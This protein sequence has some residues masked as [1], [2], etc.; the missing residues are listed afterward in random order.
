MTKQQN[1]V[2]LGPPG[3]GKGTIADLISEKTGLVHISTGEIFRREIKN[4]TELGKK[5]EAYVQAGGLVPD[6]IVAELVR[7]RLT[8]SDCDNGFIFDGFP[9][10][11]PQ[12]TIFEKVLSEIDKKVDVVISLE[13]PEELLIQRLT[14]RL[15]CKKCGMNFNKLFAPPAKENICD[16]CG[17]ELY[18]REDDS[19][20]TVVDRMRVY[21]AETAPLV[22]YYKEKQLLAPV[23]AEQTKEMIVD[24]VLKVIN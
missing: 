3:V 10:N 5:A 18:Q 9:R 1:L 15:T 19:L 12:A 21:N 7:V 17:G 16:K 20:E 6:E 13:A 8:D 22:E 14:A 11:L 2:F 4:Q 24:E 23:N